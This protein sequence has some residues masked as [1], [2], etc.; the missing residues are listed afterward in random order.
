MR[1][2]PNRRFLNDA[3]ESALCASFSAAK[4]G[5]W[6][7]QEPSP[8]GEIV[9]RMLTMLAIIGIGALLAVRAHGQSTDALIVLA[10]VGY[11][12]TCF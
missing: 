11:V 12:A 8:Q 6:G 4:P 1:L 5:C 7:L 9:S 2:P 10:T 3:F